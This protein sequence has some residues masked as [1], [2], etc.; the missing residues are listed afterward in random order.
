M[1]T[2]LYEC[3]RHYYDSVLVIPNEFPTLLA[4]REIIANALFL[5]HDVFCT[6]T[7]KGD[8]ADAKIQRI[9]E[10]AQEKQEKCYFAT[11]LHC[12]IKEFRHTDAEGKK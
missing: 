3:R 1:K 11:L 4:K 9:F 12:Y 10:K 6:A 2:L 7:A 8:Y 5:T